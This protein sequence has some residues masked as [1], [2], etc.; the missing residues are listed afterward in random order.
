MSEAMQQVREQL[1][2]LLESAKNGSLIPIRLPGQIEAIL[3]SLKQAD[4]DAK[5]EASK[6]SSGGDVGDDY[7]K[8]EAYFVGHAV[9]ELRTPMTSIRGY[10]DMLGAMGELN[11]MQQQF[12]DVIK[13]NV[14]RMEGL[15][16]DVSY[17]N[18]IRKGTLAINPKMEMAKNITGML[19]KNMTPVAE[20]LERQLEFDVPQGL[21]LVT[22]DTDMLVVALS[23]FVE[24]GLRYA[25]K[26]TGK[27]TV[28]AEAV[29]NT[30]VITIADNG[31]GISPEDKEHLGEIYFRSDHDAVRE[32]KG[33]GL[34][35]P[36]AFGMLDMLGIDYTFESEA[37]KGT[38]VTVR[39]EGMS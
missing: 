31:I 6:Q 27:V 13:T 24:N 12:M 23:K 1:N 20:E 38:T 15:L 22:V 4:D 28:K 17:M 39:I 29:E 2:E 26:E 25:P 10:S 34:G 11:E 3:D 36:I 5:A 8:E 32:Y 21:P 33:S 37:D 19:E 18:K 7:M 30:L 16:A 35:I 9:H 14:K